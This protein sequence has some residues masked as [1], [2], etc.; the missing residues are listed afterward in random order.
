MN[1]KFIKLGNTNTTFPKRLLD[2]L[3]DEEIETEGQ[4]L[5]KCKT[6]SINI[7]RFINMDLKKICIFKTVFVIQ[8][9]FQA[10]CTYLFSYFTG[11]KICK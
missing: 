2:S 4:K 5:E 10:S 9:R 8:S 11:T 7:L 1:Y 3:W 6:L